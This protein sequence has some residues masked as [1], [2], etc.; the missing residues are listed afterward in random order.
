MKRTFKTF[1]FVPNATFTLFSGRG[2]DTKDALYW[3]SKSAVWN[4]DGDTLFLRDDKG[5][6]VLSYSYP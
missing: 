5:N 1:V 4:N 2:S 3:N 6:L